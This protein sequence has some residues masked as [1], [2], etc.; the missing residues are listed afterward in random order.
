MKEKHF[1]NCSFSDNNYDT[2][3]EGYCLL[4]KCGWIEMSI[5]QQPHFLYCDGP[6]MDHCVDIRFV[7]FEEIFQVP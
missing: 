2:L 7:G 5:T 4:Y 3:Q 1:L 6:I